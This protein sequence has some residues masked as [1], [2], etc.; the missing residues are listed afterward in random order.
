MVHHGGA[1]PTPVG[2]SLECQRERGYF[3]RCSCFYPVPSG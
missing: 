3:S 2:K 1:S